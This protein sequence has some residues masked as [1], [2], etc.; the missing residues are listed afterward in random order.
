MTPRRSRIFCALCLVA[1]FTLFASSCSDS[2][3]NQVAKAEADI[4]A[5]CA[6][7]FTV[8]AQANAANPPLISNSDAAAIIQVLLQIEQG[9]RQAETATGQISS[10]N[11]TNSAS[12]LTV[13]APIETAVNNAVANGTVNIKDPSTKT[14][15]QTALVTIQT[16]LNSTVAL[17][18]AVK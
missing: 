15:V 7:T 2:T 10:L 6:A 4:N 11:A 1:C 3:L 16:L 8:V 12:I 9:N 17:L 18:Q 13:L 14:K 5:A